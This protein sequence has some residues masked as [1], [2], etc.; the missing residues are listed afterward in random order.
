MAQQ[1]K[2]STKLAKAQKPPALLQNGRPG[3]NEQHL[4]AAREALLAELA[5]SNPLQASIARDIVEV[6]S[7]L[8]LLPQR[9]NSILWQSAV[10]P[11]HDLI[12]RSGACDQEAAEALAIAWATGSQDAEDKIISFGIDP[13]IAHNQVYSENILLIREIERQIELLERRRRQL[14]ADYDRLNPVR[15]TAG[16]RRA[17][18]IHDAEIIPETQ[19][20]PADAT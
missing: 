17:N 6:D 8:A 4:A 20:E 7:D 16:P 5:P 14:L 10:S 1:G 18:E 11:M 9:R 19:G 13:A 2:S 3:A 15:A 12:R